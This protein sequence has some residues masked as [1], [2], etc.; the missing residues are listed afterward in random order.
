MTAK[1]D[2]RKFNG[3]HSGTGPKPKDGKTKMFNIRIGETLDARLTK[4]ADRQ[5]IGKSTLIKNL[6]DL[7]LPL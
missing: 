3:G 7:H 5:N 6:L 2:R 1:I 4:E